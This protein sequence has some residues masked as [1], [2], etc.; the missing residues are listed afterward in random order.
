MPAEQG[1][2]GPASYFTSIEKTC[3]KPVSHWLK[4]LGSMK[5]KK[6]MEMMAALTGMRMRWWPA[7]A[8]GLP[9]AERTQQTRRRP[10]SV[11][12]LP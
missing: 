3:G 7:T 10:A 4:L 1:A 5:G 6:H 11:R 12:A 9:V 8:P 2:K